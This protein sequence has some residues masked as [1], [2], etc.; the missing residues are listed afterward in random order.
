V[1]VAPPPQSLTA[2]FEFRGEVLRWKCLAVSFSC[3]T[4]SMVYGK[5][6]N[7]AIR[8]S[9]SGSDNKHSL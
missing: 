6:M 7:G 5:L 2:K 8:A 3:A 1:I 9:V 4:K